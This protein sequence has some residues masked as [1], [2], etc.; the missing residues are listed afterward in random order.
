MFATSILQI[1]PWKSP[2]QG[3]LVL[4][5]ANGSRERSEA[6]SVEQ[7]IGSRCGKMLAPLM[8][9]VGASRQCPPGG[10]EGAGGAGGRGRRLGR[11]RDR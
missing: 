6:A 7:L 9:L 2:A 5:C 10:S 11:R 8:R 3:C 1:V 4:A